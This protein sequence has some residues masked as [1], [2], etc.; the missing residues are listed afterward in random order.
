[1]TSKFVAL[2]ANHLRE[3]PELTRR[4]ALSEITKA[5][6]QAKRL[7]EHHEPMAATRTIDVSVRPVEEEG[8][9]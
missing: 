9:P 4:G 8:Q 1:L 2:V 6:N 5:A 3:N 7:L